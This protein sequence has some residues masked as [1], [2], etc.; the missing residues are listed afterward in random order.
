[1]HPS[2]RG[3]V[4]TFEETCLPASKKCVSSAASLLKAN[5]CLV[6]T[7]LLLRGLYKEPEP[8]PFPTCFVCFQERE[9]KRRRLQPGRV[10]GSRSIRLFSVIF[11]QNFIHFKY[12]ICLFLFPRGVPQ[13]LLVSLFLFALDSL[14]FSLGFP[15]LLFLGSSFFSLGGGGGGWWCSVFVCLRFR[16]F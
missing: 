11:F 8:L 15:F 2:F 13:F 6:G 14:L 12:L 3:K 16:P 9:R 4:L 10:K 7:E 1:M 5:R